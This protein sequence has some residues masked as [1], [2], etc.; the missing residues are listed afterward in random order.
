MKKLLTIIA[1]FASLAISVSANAQLRS[2]VVPALNGGNSITLGTIGTTISGTG[3]SDTLAV[4]DTI[5][6]IVP[7]NSIYR[8]TPFLSFGWNK[9]GSGTA[10]VTATFYQGN[11]PY[12]FTQ[13]K[14]GSANNLYSKSFTLSASGT[15]FVDFLAD[16]VKVSGKYLKIQY[17]TSGTASVQGSVVSVLSTQMH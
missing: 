17:M 16:S 11:S 5:A 7:I 6:Y 9:I 2:K 15:N 14:A 12:N 4:S 1:I 3:V 13:C 8:Y 10:T